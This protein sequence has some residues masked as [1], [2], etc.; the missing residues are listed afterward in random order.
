MTTELIKN[1]EEIRR[2][3]YSIT[4]ALILILVV[5]LL[6]VISIDK[7]LRVQN[8]ILAVAHEVDIEKIRKNQ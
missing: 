5:I 6:S 4:F 7:E 8:E 3:L 1:L 2:S